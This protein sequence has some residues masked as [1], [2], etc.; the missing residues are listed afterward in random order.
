MIAISLNVPM[1]V[2][3][4]WTIHTIRVYPSL[5]WFWTRTLCHTKFQSN[6]KCFCP[7]PRGWLRIRVLTPKWNQ[8]C[9]VKMALCGFCQSVNLSSHD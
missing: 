3:M 4:L 5:L 2:D 7:T 9:N 1:H 6:D 8:S